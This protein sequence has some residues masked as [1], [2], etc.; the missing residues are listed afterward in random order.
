MKLFKHASYIYGMSRSNRDV[1]YALS[2]DSAQV[3]EH[4]VKYFYITDP[5]LRKHW[6]SEI[7]GFFH[8][9]DTLKS[10]K[11]FPSVKFIMD[12]TY[13]AHADSICIQQKLILSEYYD[14]SELSAIKFND[15][16]LLRFIKQ[17]FT[18]LA[19][20]LNHDGFVTIKTVFDYVYQAHE[21]ALNN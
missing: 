3:F 7:Y 4:L 13:E 12:N 19:D 21:Y 9:V 16:A 6:I 8:K 18:L 10:T 20:K 15:A 17:Y 2:H 14:G 5:R 11:R 1:R